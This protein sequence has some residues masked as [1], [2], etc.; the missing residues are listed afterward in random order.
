MQELSD[1]VP[2]GITDVILSVATTGEP[3]EAGEARGLPVID[4]RDEPLA[5]TCAAMTT[6]V[7]SADAAIT[8]LRELAIGEAAISPAVATG[9]AKPGPTQ[10]RATGGRPEQDPGPAPR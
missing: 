2:K 6:D 7:V 8:G 1:E 5:P 4:L 3:G 10:S 9:D